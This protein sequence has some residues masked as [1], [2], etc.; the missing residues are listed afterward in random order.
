MKAVQ[1][2]EYGGPEVLEVVDV[3][4]P[5]AEPG[6]VRI[7]VRAAG[8][9][10]P[11][12]K[13]RSGVRRDFFPRTLPA[14]VGFEAAGVVDEVGEGVTG[15]SVGDSVFG[16][17]EPTHAEFAILH[18]WAKK[19]DKMPF[20]EAGA[21][22]VGGETAF[23][24]LERMGVARGETLLVC[25]AA[26]G[27]GSAVVQLARWRGIKVIGT[28]SPAKQDYLRSLGADATTYEAGWVDR[29][30]ALAPNG[31]DAAMDVVGANAFAE[32]IE[33]TGDPSKVGSIMLS[34]ADKGIIT[35][36]EREENPARLLAE[37]ARAF[38]EGGLRM[39]VERTFS[40]AET[41][42]A[43]RISAE[44]TTLGKLVVIPS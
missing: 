27:V 31:V 28:D 19:P 1:F 11:D 5:H 33:L 8:V 3:E 34:D 37:V 24:I 20:E 17:G 13:I 15:V 22:A 44:G 2:K 25:G 40:L 14:G 29:V 23:R 41:G 30:K 9:N 12:W 43:H 39:R 21:I 6:Q 38:K 16:F 32:L 35:T 26:G 7:A 36:Y 4:E 10:P 42:E 18:S